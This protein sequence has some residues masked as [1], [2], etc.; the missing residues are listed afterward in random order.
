MPNLPMSIN[1]ILF[2]LIFFFLI[3]LYVS[4][5]IMITYLYQKGGIK[6]KTALRCISWSSLLKY[7]ELKRKE[8]GKLD[9]VGLAYAISLCVLLVLALIVIVF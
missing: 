6:E 8:D 3:I 4:G 9:F 1:I 7:Y 2:S 5:N